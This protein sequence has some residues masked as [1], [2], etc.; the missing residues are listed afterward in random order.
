MRREDRM[1][2]DRTAIEA[3][4][5]E[6]TVCR[7]GLADGGE[8]YVVPVC[9]GYEDGAL[10]LHSAPDGKKIAL[11]EKNPSCCFEVDICDQVIRGDCP[12][13]WGMRYRS[14][15]GYGRAAILNDPAEKRHGLNC[16]MRHY[17]G[18]THEFS[19]RDI[20]SVAVI[21]IAIGSMTGKK[22]V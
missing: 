7:I 19:D 10:Y 16:I 3:I 1:I 4:L 9:F 6:A 2:T 12:C 13:S 11:L 21:R 22:H 17:H 20:R 15:I 14:V 8:P 18:G 5:N